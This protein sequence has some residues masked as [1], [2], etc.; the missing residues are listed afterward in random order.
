MK[1]TDK[2]KF[3][4]I[5]NLSLKGPDI[6]RR[7]ANRTL[8]TNGATGQYSLDAEV[9]ETRRMT[10]MDIMNKHR[11]LTGNIANLQKSMSNGN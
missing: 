4:V 1:K 10:K 7:I 9:D 11:E 5:P 8:I 2:N 6:M 3:K